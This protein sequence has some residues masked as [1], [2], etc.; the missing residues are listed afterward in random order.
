[1]YIDENSFN[2]DLR[3][4]PGQSLIFHPSQI[5]KPPKSKYY[6]VVCIDINGIVAVKIIKGGVKSQDFFHM[7]QRSQ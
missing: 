5:S 6:S 4:S 7:Y 1:M 2:L 3:S